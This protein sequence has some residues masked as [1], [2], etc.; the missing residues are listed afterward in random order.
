MLIFSSLI[1]ISCRP[2]TPRTPSPLI[3]REEPPTPPQPQPATV[4]TKKL[5]PGPP[6]PRRVIIKRIPPLPA[7][8]RPVIIEKWLPYKQPPERPVLYERAEHIEAPRPPQRNVILQ[9]EPAKV[10]VEQEV[11]NV[12]CY[13]VDPEIYRA[14][15]GS[16]LRRTNSIRRVL[17]DIGCNPDLITSTGY[18][19]DAMIN[20]TADLPLYDYSH[21]QSRTTIRPNTTCFTDEQLAELV[22]NSAQSSP[23]RHR[24]QTVYTMVIPSV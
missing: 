19:T 15:Y 22:G 24:S 12:G 1:E 4:I 18:Q 8:P 2:L 21:S 23:P 5:P 20:R 11:Q 17:Q 7:K 9:Y 16:C 6:P 10:R 14:Q 13:R 3:V